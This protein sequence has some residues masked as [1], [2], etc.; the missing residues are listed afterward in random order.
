M[1]R[2]RSTPAW[3]RRP[4]AA[5]PRPRRP[6]WSCRPSAR[7]ASGSGDAGWPRWG[8]ATRRH[9]LHHAPGP[10]TP[11]D[12][13]DDHRERRDGGAAREGPRSA[14]ARTAS[15]ST[16]CWSSSARA[17]WPRS[18]RPSAAAR[19]CALKRP[20]TA[21]PRRPGVPRALPARGRDRPH[22]APP[23]HHPHLRARRGRTACRTSRWSWWRARP[24][25]RSCAAA[26][27]CRRGSA[28]G[29]VAQVAEAL[30][31]A[32]LKGVVHRDLKP[33]NIMILRATAR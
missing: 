9:H 33:S 19:V 28:A 18:S 17:A 10:R 32:H 14:R 24:C 13:F 16:A 22:A 29:I 5:L 27:R 31:Y 2:P 20:L 8:S 4:A 25:R 26:G 11:V 1:G 23:E 7:W 6:W 30:D 3:R 12:A 15:A 21:L